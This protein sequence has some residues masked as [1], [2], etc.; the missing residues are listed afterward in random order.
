MIKRFACTSTWFRLAIPVRVVCFAAAGLLCAGIAAAQSGEKSGALPAF[1][2]LRLDGPEELVYRSNALGCKNPDGTVVTNDHSDMP[3]RAFRDYTGQVHLLA[4]SRQN[5]QAVGPSLNKAARRGC[6]RTVI[7]RGNGAPEAFDEFQ[8]LMSAYTED[9]RT[10]IGLTHHEYHGDLHYPECS[11]NSKRE[12]AWEMRCWYTS[13]NLVESRDGGYTFSSPSGKSQP[14]A[15]LPYRF[16]TDMRRAGPH[17]PTNIVRN[18][19]DRYYY[20]MFQASAYRDQARGTC[21]MRTTDLKKGQWL[22]WGGNAF[23]VKFENP[24]IIAVAD[25]GKH[26]CKPVVPWLGNSLTYNTRTHSFL[27]IGY[28][29]QGAVY[30]WSR[31]LVRWSDRDT[32]MRS[33]IRSRAGREGASEATAH[34]S[35]LDPESPTLSF[36]QTGARF[37]LYY[38]KYLKGEA[39]GERGWR[40][41]ARELVR[42]PVAVQ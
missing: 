20:V 27:L 11:G 25:P 41:G 1:P 16:S 7:S 34:Y 26:V 13:I 29:S 35:A 9:G 28:S 18:P 14:V 2:Q 42:R 33:A 39:R 17:S 3:A 21:V 22:A 38:T 12:G 8:W 15:V 4:S 19:E 40:F 23:D 10:V 30:A 37:Y 32:L 31:D 36:D 5:F 6:D 24:Y